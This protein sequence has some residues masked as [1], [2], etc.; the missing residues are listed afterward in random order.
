[1]AR[2]GHLLWLH[3]LDWGS[4]GW[5]EPFTAQALPVSCVYWFS[6]AQILNTNLVFIDSK[7]YSGQQQN[8]YSR[9]VYPWWGQHL[10]SAPHN[11]IILR[12][13][14]TV[15]CLPLDKLLSQQDLNPNKNNN[16]AVN[17]FDSSNVFEWSVM[18]AIKSCSNV[19]WQLCWHLLNKL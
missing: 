5:L 1:M 19:R 11:F 17:Y 16:H 12:R 2:R 6:P 3:Y 15:Y 4:V 18:I 8:C 10:N 7:D 13:A 9:G 14:E